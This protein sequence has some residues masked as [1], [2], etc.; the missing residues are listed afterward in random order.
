MYIFQKSSPLESAVS[1]F[2]TALM[3]EMQK[4]VRT[5]L[6]HK[7]FGH[8]VKAILTKKLDSSNNETENR[9]NI[10]KKASMIN[11]ELESK[12][13]IL[14]SFKK[15]DHFSKTPKVE[16]NTKRNRSII[17]QN[18]VPISLPMD[19]ATKIGNT[20]VE[21]N[22]CARCIGFRKLSAEVKSKIKFLSTPAASSKEEALSGIKTSS[23][24]NRLENRIL[25]NSVDND[26][27]K[28]NRLKS[29]KK[30]LKFHKSAIHDWGLYALENVEAGDL[31]IEYVGQVI[32]QK[33]ADIR[34]IRYEK[35]G[36]GSSYLFRVDKHVVID[37]TKMGNLARFINHSCE[38][39]KYK[40]N[41]LA[42]FG[43][44]SYSH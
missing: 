30:A 35:R 32:R 41:Y 12:S 11:D 13:A 21:N 44:K 3:A 17:V 43:S 24:N 37:A 33:V 4:L 25:Q 8:S 34:E 5:E 27:L 23:R 20:L 26:V 14:P 42:E 31:I 1:V 18:D 19:R 16:K 2:I 28:F 6:F 9:I 7:W 22:S 10:Y 29:R 40:F 15:K 38:V 36:I 39:R